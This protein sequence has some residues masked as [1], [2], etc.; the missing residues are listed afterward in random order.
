M[1]RTIKELFERKS[2]RAYTD[3]PITSEERR[4]ILESAIQAPTAGNMA[5]YSIIDIQDQDL[6]EELSVLCDHQPFIAKAPMVLVFLADYQKWYDMFDACCETTPKIEEADLFLAMEDCLIAAQNAVVA[7]QSLGIGSCYIGDILENFEQSQKLLNL[8]RYAV[9]CAMAVFGR[10]TMQQTERT[11]PKRFAVDDIVHVNAY[12]QK[13]LDET[14]EMFQ[15]QTGK[16]GE[17]LETYIK[18]FAKRK[19]YASFREEMNR[20]VKAILKYWT[21]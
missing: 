2:I 10:P 5:L 13:S 1:N 9:P 6:K 8:P 7:A 14:R 19:F 11:K 16:S 12:H 17:E 3:D 4:L 15:R 21:D 20:S 18:A